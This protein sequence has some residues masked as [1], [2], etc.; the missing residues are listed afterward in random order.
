MLDD[1]GVRYWLEA[2][3][4]LGAMRSGD[5]LPWDHDV[6]IG[7]ETIYYFRQRL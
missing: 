2:G 3:S 1:A 6:D 7:M 4:L 5:V